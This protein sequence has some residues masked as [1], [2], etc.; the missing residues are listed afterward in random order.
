MTPEMNE[1]RNHPLSRPFPL[2]AHARAR[3]VESVAH[4]EER[5][6]LRVKKQKTKK[7]PKKNPNKPYNS[8]QPLR[9]SSLRAPIHTEATGIRLA[10]NSLSRNYIS[11]LS[12]RSP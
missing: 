5:T 8:Q 10:P 4:L 11:R 9:V 7:Q 3:A 6:A 2:L 1:S 12:P